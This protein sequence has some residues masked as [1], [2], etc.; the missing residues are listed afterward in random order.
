MALQ[1]KNTRDLLTQGNVKLK[2]ITYSPSGF[3]KTEFAATAPNP[4][5]GACETGH[6]KGL[7][8]VAQKGIPYVEIGT[9]EQLESFCSG[10]GLGPYDTIVLDGFSYATDTAIKTYALSVPRQRGESKKRLMGIP[11]MDD[12]G[13]MAELERRLLAKLLSLD[14]HIIITCLQDYYQPAEGNGD[15]PRAEKI[16]GPDLPGMM[17]LGAAAMVDIV[18][19]LFMRNALKDPKDAKSRYN[20]RVWQTE[21]DGKYLAKSRIRNGRLPVFPPEVV[22]DLDRNIGTFDWM[23]Q[24]ANKAYAAILPAGAS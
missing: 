2:M 1:I 19:R 11:E 4:I 8:T 9:Y 3:G 20:E 13:T 10:D 21:S 16:G 6:G 7:L 18:L 12:Y 5:F 24:Q 15:M 14:K 17:R 22:F 23:L